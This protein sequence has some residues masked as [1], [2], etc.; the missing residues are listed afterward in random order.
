LETS[1]DVL[2]TV[3]MMMIVSYWPVAAISSEWWGVGR[4][5]PAGSRGRAPGQW[6]RGA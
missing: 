2:S 5:S 1:G 4:G 3:D 6:V